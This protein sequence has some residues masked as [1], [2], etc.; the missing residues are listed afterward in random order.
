MH[1]CQDT[2]VE[3]ILIPVKAAYLGYARS[4][5]ST[6]GRYG[7]DFYNQSNRKATRTIITFMTFWYHVNLK[8]LLYKVSGDATLIV[9][10][11][12]FIKQS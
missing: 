4:G 6:Q 3:N 11:N 12:S 5:R 2:A 7:S 1:D 10:D 8:V 9:K